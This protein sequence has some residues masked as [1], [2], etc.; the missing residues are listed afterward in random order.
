MQTSK[1]AH[2]AWVYLPGSLHKRT[3]TELTLLN[4]LY[5]NSPLDTNFE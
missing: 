5:L 4:K 1:V 2:L 3:K